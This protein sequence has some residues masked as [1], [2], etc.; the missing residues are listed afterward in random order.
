MEKAHETIEYIVYAM[1]SLWD[2]ITIKCLATSA[3]VAYAFI[4]GDVHKTGHMAVLL[5]I[6]ADF[7]TGISAAKMSGDEIKSSKI[8]RSAVKA[9]IY[10]IMI[11]GAHLV[12]VA[13]PFVT[14]TDETVLA[15]LACTELISIMENSGKM[16]FAI[17]K[18]L[19][20]K[21]Q[22]FRDSK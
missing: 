14:F 7:I 19:L 16:G 2:Y 4:F 5:L 17:P 6:L 13:A 21:L 15:F 12:E 18:K 10:F 1:R 3:Y 8:V 22:D 9:L 11:A 20:N